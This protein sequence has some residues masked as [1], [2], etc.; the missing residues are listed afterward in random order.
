MTG[1]DPK[2]T[3]HNQGILIVEE[4]N[5][6]SVSYLCT[7][8]FISEQSLYYGPLAYLLL[9]AARETEK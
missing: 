6:V 9:L 5:S 7:V 4:K 2:Y 8:L 1:I 3:K